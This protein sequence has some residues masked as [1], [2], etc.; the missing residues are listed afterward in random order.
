MNHAPKPK[1]IEYLL[2]QLSELFGQ[3]PVL[4]GSE[5]IAAYQ[6]TMRLFAECFEPQDFFE[7]TLMK[8]VTDGTWEVARWRRHKVLW[9]DRNVRERRK[10]EAQLKELAAKNAGVAYSVAVEKA[11][12]AIKPPGDCDEPPSELEHNRAI[13]GTLVQQEK[14]MKMEMA[15]LAKRNR[16]IR[17]LECYRDGLGRRLGAISDEFIADYANSATSAPAEVDAG[18][19][20]TAGIE[21]ADAPA[22]APR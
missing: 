14:L 17:Q 18:T 9:L 3:P 2:A 22:V 15:A 19:E 11:D 6:K 16:A 21:T 7:S 5:S 8:D 4:S 20:T 10:A 13:A 1:S 12:P